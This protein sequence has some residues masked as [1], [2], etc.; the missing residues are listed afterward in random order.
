MSLK[1]RLLAVFVIICTLAGVVFV[2]FRGMTIPKMEQESIFHKKDAIYF[3]YTDDSL[4]DYINSAAVTFG[5]E[6]DIRVIPVLKSGMEYLEA[7]NQASL[8]DEEALPDVYLLSNDS[9][10]KAY[11]AGL[12]AEVDDNGVCSV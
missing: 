7:V 12:A 9:L 6:N 10:E 1:K 5:E 4:T 3:W 2:G 11:L 8:T